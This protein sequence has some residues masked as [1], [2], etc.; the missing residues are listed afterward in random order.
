MPPTPTR[1][2]TLLASLLLLF[3][4]T[5]PAMADSAAPSSLPQVDFSKMGAV[6]LGGSFSGLDWWSDD[7]P[8]ASSSSS[9]TTFSTDGDTLFY[10]TAE[11]R[12]RPLAS[13]DA[14]GVISALCWSAGTDDSSNGTLYVGGTFT[15]LS[16]T[17]VNNVASFALADGSVN[18]LGTGLSGEVDTVY[19]DDDNSQVWF[20]GSFDAPTG[21]GGNVALW[22]TASSVWETPAFGG[23]NG[24]VESISPSSNGS[25]IYFGGDFT[26]SYVSNSTV[27]ANSSSI[28]NGTTGNSTTTSVESA[29]DNTTTVGNSGYLTPLTVSASSSSSA[30]Y[31]IQAGP[32]TDQ[33]EYS[34]TDVLLCPDSG[35]WLAQD[36]TIASVNV[37]GQS[38]LAATG[39]RVVNGLVEG[40]GTTTF[41]LTMLPWYAD[42]N[43]TYTDPITGEVNTCTTHC[44]L[45]N[46]SSTSAQDFIFTEGTQNLT[47]FE[48]QLKGW[49]G[50][51]AGLSSVS[52]LTDGAYISAASSS[53]DTVTCSSGSNNNGSIQ[54]TGD[55]E[56]RTIATDSA[57]NSYLEARNSVANPTY[58]SVTFYP[59]VSSAG[60]YDIYIFIPGC[61]NAGD[62]NS[63]TS[64]D[65]EVFPFSGGM[66]WTSTISEQVDYDTKTLVY[67][68][69][70]GASTDDFTPTVS[71]ALSS[72]PARPARGNRYTVVA[73]KVQMTLTSLSGQ[74]NNANSSTTSTSPVLNGTSAG[75]PDT[76]GTTTI[77]S[78][79]M[80]NLSY[81][82]AYGV[83]EWPRTVALNVNAATSALSNVTETP[84][85][86]LGFSLD[87]A[88]NASGS[89]ASAWVVN[90]VVAHDNTVFV[91]GDFSSTNNYTNVLSID[92]S[93]G[94]ASA[95]ASQGLG[96]IVNTAVVADGYVFFGGDFTATAS[97]GETGLMYVARYDPSSK[98]WAALGGGV[99]GLVTDL[100][101]SATSTTEVIVIGNFTSVINADGSTN[102][103][104]GFAIWDDKNQEWT[105]TGVLFGNVSAGAV[106]SS[107]LEEAYFAGKVY[108]SANN[109]VSG[110]AV[111]S[112]NSDGSAAIS[113]LNGVSFGTAGSAS[114]SSNSTSTRRSLNVNS[115]VSRSWLSRFTDA[116]VE[117]TLPGL[118]PRATAPTIVSASY[119]AP[120]VLAGTYWTNSSA[121]GEPTV[122]IL[123]G[124]FTSSSGN[125]EGVAFHSKSDD[126]LTGPTTAVT[127]VV[128]ALDV[129]G[130]KLYVGGEG[131]T[132]D[133]V[134]G[135]LVVYDLKQ[136]SWVTSGMASLNAASD[137]DLIVNQIRTRPNTNTI[138]VAGN[139]ASAGSLGCAGVC[140]WDSEGGRWSTPG[141][142]LSS[143][144]VRSLDFAGNSYDT[145]IAAGSFVLSDGTVASVASYN[146]GNSSWTALGSLSGPALAVVADDK[147]ATNV[148][149]AG[150][151][152][153]DGSP[154]L[155][156]WNGVTWTAQNDSLQS[157]SLVQ[158]LAFVPM[159]SEHTA[160]GTIENDRMLLVSGDLYLENMGNATSALYDGANW[161]PYLVGSSSSGGIGAGSSLFWS[162]S[163]F[164]FKVKH[165]LAR[166]LVVLVAIAIATGLIL[167]FILLMLLLAYFNRRR[168]NR[169]AQERQEAFGKEGS[170]VSSTHQNVFANVQAALEASLVG[171]GLAGAGVAAATKKRESSRARDRLS[172][173]SSYNSGAYPIGS[174]AGGYADD[175]DEAYERETTMRYDFDG[176]ELQEGEMAMKAGQ[177]VV[178]LDDEQSHEWWYARDPATGREGM[179]PATYVW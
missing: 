80:T 145:L 89:D 13:T 138:V 59:Y 177:A 54:T 36:N 21:T 37:V 172:D 20:G 17:D 96:G 165:F 79:S 66:G 150:Y 4:A 127:G 10:R 112:T 88:L 128:R 120:A 56:S 104:G 7:S 58:P 142:G 46:S 124:N 94:E 48:M 76:N 90:T 102:Q 11:G 63:R 166:G 119:P 133:G 157:G 110:V 51:G 14:G 132:V 117:R 129:V 111:L 151:S 121:S 67:S 126:A 82:I 108:G 160:Q 135:G 175:D 33:S 161:Y 60:N 55:W 22:S 154:F 62:C 73:D 29:P 141:S 98:A 178:I 176:P 113:S 143:G 100:L 92:A 159:S 2:P 156:Q 64:V 174:D 95:L 137:S 152:S 101:A 16:G 61:L 99:D 162:D 107:S 106:P 170:V 140:L 5:A 173:P 118:L 50:D 167:L 27:L 32:S 136:D 116:L 45:Y 68:G 163:D 169:A 123:G 9:E 147:N 164:S 69:T 42:L 93:S 34:N 77:N 31:Q 72:S 41:C 75:T 52:L 115:M 49:L 109:A 65:I 114:A 25:S 171:G 8:Y 44:P 3:T 18:A 153:S 84:L 144:E 47:G 158:Q 168:D 71:L 97:S 39:I 28:T 125:V 91:G 146:F 57:T 134:G 131:V 81:N 74:G 155:E 83:Y 149:A 6:G 78:T 139:F 148:Y 53:D 1:H 122:T 23:L 85:A 38:Y 30:S 24:R 179:I 19:C 86:R 35:I 26:I 15:T 12:F 70:V 43:M 87:A 103:T 130:D 105:T 40:R